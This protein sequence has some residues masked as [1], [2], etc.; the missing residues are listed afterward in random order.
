MDV[1]GIDDAAAG[2]GGQ[3]IAR[4]RTRVKAAPSIARPAEHF[5]G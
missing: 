5:T 4:E 1:C 3:P 2:D